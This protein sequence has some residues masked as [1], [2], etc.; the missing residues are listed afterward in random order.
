MG[1]RGDGGM[2]RG[3]V[4]PSLET[5]CRLRDP[6]GVVGGSSLAGELDDLDLEDETGLEDVCDRGSLQ[7]CLTGGQVSNVAQ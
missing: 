6:M 5:R 4:P 7:S 1:G 2:E 3:I